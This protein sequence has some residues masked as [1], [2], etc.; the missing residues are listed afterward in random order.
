[1]RLC[2]DSYRCV[3]GMRAGVEQK[4]YRQGK[5]SDSG[6]NAFYVLGRH[7]VFL[8]KRNGSPRSRQ[9]PTATVARIKLA[10]SKTG[11]LKNI[12]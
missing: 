10:C 6:A 9:K 2:F 3:F 4:E 7:G 5:T 12:T 1:M 8:M 11:L